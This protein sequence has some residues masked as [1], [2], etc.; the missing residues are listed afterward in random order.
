MSSQS[1]IFNWE[2]FIKI[3]E[4]L[5]TIQQSQFNPLRNCSSEAIYRTICSRA[6]YGIFKQIE[7]FLEENSVELKDTIE[8]TNEKGE[9][10]E[11]KLGSHERVIIYLRDKNSELYKLIDRLR[12]KRH[13]ADYKAKPKIK[14]RDAKEAYKKAKEAHELFLQSRDMLL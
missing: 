12:T 2:E 9:I 8:I 10:E 4:E 6:Y 14:E 5:Y 13:Q 11:R 3:S 1:E 7:D